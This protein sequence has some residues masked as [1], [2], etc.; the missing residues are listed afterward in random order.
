I[1][2]YWFFSMFHMSNFTLGETQYSDGKVV[3]MENDKEYNRVSEQLI[4][5]LKNLLLGSEI[6]VYKLITN[7]PKGEDE[8]EWEQIYFDVGSKVFVL[9]F[10]QWG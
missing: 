9:D 10:Y 5:M 4:T 7:P 6:R 3:S 2:T 8:F 1:C